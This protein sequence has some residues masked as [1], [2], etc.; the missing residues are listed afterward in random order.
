MSLASLVVAVLFVC[1]YVPAILVALFCLH[2]PFLKSLDMFA[3]APAAVNATGVFSPG[4]LLKSARHT[5]LWVRLVRRASLW[6]RRRVLLVL[7]VS[8]CHDAPSNQ[9]GRPLLARKS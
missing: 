2:G 6:V 8:R 7:R 5:L 1:V 3:T 4:L 9:P